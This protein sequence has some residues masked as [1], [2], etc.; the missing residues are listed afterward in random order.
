M[1]APTGM[2][3]PRPTSL[4][5]VRISVRSAVLVVGGLAL[6]VLTLRILRSA[7]RVIGWMAF[8]AA[9]AML[10]DP[11]VALLARWIPRALATFLVLVLGVGLT[12]GAVYGLVSD[13]EKQTNRLERTLPRIARDLERGSRFREQF[14]DFELTRRTREFVQNIPDVLQGGSNEEALRSAPERGAAVLATIVL[15]LFFLAYGRRGVTAVVAQIR[16]PERREGTARVVSGAYRNAS[17]Y[18]L[19]TAGLAVLTGAFTYVVGRAAGTPGPVAVAVWA[20][21]WSLVPV[22][23]ALVGGIPLVALAAVE[24]GR[25]WIAVIAVLVA[26]H[27]LKGLYLR[28]RLERRTVRVGPF[29]TAFAAVTG[30]E[31]YGLGGALVWIAG[32]TVLLAV[33]DQIRASALPSGADGGGAQE[34]EPVG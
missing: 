21:L 33:T 2:P 17:R 16:D 15:L 14:H 18:A 28:R 11:I 13:V 10:L 32:V 22:F 26:F 1:A 3:E 30:L 29:L 25:G 4:P 6:A 27:V 5:Q 34:H 12:A 31:L 20:A 9:I 19:G 8:A 23:G 24:P 7:E